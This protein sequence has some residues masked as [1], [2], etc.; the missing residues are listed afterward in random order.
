MMA[1]GSSGGVVTFTAF[2]T[3]IVDGTIAATC[4]PASNSLFA[5]GTTTVTC[6][7][8]DAHGNVASPATFKIII[9]RKPVNLNKNPI[10]F[11]GS[12]FT[13]FF[14]NLFPNNVIPVTG[15]TTF[16]IQCP[17]SDFTQTFDEYSV[18][19]TDLCKNYQGVVET[20][21]DVV[22][23]AQLPKG[24]S[25]VTSL[26]VNVLQNGKVISPL[27]EGAAITIDFQL[28][29]GVKAE[30]VAVLFWDGTNWIEVTG[31]ATKDGYQASNSNGGVFVLVQK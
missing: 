12:L 11:V 18:T 25:L 23:P 30:N 24:K 22:L 16:D 17:P 19:F 13:N 3:D 15:G 2:A 10:D 29:D 8:T 31:A 14:N 7:A 20:G 27:P 4:S 21:K 6:S 26:Y 5:V 1:S 9:E 28:P